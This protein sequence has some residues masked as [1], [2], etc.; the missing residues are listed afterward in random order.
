MINWGVY[1]IFC[2]VRLG[3]NKLKGREVITVPGMRRVYT[4]YLNIPGGLVISEIFYLGAKYNQLI[5]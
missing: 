5:G 4:W 2:L 1:W 3:I